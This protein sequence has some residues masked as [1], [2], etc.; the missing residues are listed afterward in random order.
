[1]IKPKIVIRNYCLEDAK[2]LMD[3][4]YNTIHKVNIKDYTLEQVDEWASKSDM[5]LEIWGKRFN[6]SKPIVAVVD[7][8]IVGFTEFKRDGYIDCFYCHHEWI[9]KG[10]GSALMEEIFLRAKKNK[11][12]RIFV[13]VSITAKPFFEKIIQWKKLSYN[14][15]INHFIAQ[16]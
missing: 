6:K 7:G 10:V 2:A 13:D 8:K 3:I 9:G 5:K 16:Y 1:M 11:I 12:K 4:F 14:F 15:H